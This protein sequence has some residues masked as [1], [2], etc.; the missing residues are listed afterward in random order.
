MV[1]INNFNKCLLK[2]DP[3]RE[4]HHKMHKVISLRDNRMAVNQDV[5]EKEKKIKTMPHLTKFG[6]KLDNSRN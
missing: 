2:T 1:N 3:L 5:G 6:S 4:T